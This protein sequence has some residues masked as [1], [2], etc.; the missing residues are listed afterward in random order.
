MS[1]SAGYT[2]INNFKQQHNANRGRTYLIG[3]LTI[4]ALLV[5]LSLS[6]NVSP[7]AGA[8][9]KI[10]SSIS[11]AR[12]TVKFP[13]YSL[14]E[15]WQ[16]GEE[17]YQQSIVSRKELIKKLGPTHADLHSFPGEVSPGALICDGI[18]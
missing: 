16:Q 15:K 13:S 11:P 18:C 3:G 10:W 6:S 9:S 7:A 4:T 8:G 2:L 17:I 5:V 1:M 12:Y 14:D